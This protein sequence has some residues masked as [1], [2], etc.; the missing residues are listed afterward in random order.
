M[1]LEEWDAI[2]LLLVSSSSLAH[3][4]WYCYWLEEEEEGS[5]C[6]LL[7]MGLLRLPLLLRLRLLLRLGGVASW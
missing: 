1:I 2:R 6:E 3:S 4:Y 5:S 7:W